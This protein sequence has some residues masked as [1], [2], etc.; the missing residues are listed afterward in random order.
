MLSEVSQKEKDRYHMI[1][2]IRG[3][4][5]MAQM[6]LSIEQ[7]QTHRCGQQTCSCQERGE[8]KWMDW[9][10]GVNRCKLLY[11]GRID[12]ESCCKAQGTMSNHL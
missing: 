4:E 2:L 1:S 12:N 5:N 3:I 8:G 6:N 10:F 11:L 7:K 9:E